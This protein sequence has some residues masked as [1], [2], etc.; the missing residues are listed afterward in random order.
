MAWIPASAGMT[1]SDPLIIEFPNAL[2]ILALP[3]NE[4]HFWIRMYQDIEK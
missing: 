4:N 1:N 2:P 3:S